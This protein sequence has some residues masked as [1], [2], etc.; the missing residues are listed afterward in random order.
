MD[1]EDDPTAERVCKDPGLLKEIW[2]A[3][4]FRIKK[5]IDLSDEDRAFLLRLR[6]LLVGEGVV[7]ADD[8]K[9]VQGLRIPVEPA[10]MDKEGNEIFKALGYRIERWPIGPG[11]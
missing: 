8:G 11:G 9:T 4:G 7:K 5:P 10:E 6:L 1:G 2:P 3:K